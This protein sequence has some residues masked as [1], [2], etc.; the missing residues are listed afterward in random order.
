MGRISSRV[1]RRRHAM[2]RVSSYLALAA[3]G[4]LASSAYGTAYTWKGTANGNWDNT[5][6]WTFT[7]PGTFPSAAADTATFSG[8]VTANQPVLD[9]NESIGELIFSTATG[10]WNIGGTST[11]TL[12]A[13]GGIGINALSQTSG[14]TTISDNFLLAANQTWEVGAGGT[15]LFTGTIEATNPAA[16]QSL[17]IAGGGT[18]NI[19]GNSIVSGSTGLSN[20]IVSSGTLD[21]SGGGVVNTAALT[22]SGGTVIDDN[23]NG[24][25]T[26]P[27]AG[28]GYRFG[29]PGTT[30]PFVTNL[31]G[32]T[33]KL[34]GNAGTD[35]FEELGTTT[36]GAGFNTVTVSSN[37]ATP[38][39]QLDTLNRAVGGGILFVNGTGLGTTGSSYGQISIANGLGGTGPGAVGSGQAGTTDTPS[40]Q[41]AAI[42]PYVLGEVP[43]S[44]GAVGSQ[45]GV[46]DTFVAYTSGGTLRP[47]NPVD[48]YSHVVNSTVNG[49]NVYINSATTASTAT[50]NSL[51]INGGDLAIGD[52]QTVTDSS[53]ALLFVSSNGIAP[54]NTTGTF[55]LGNGTENIVSVNPGITGTISAAL[56]GSA[57][58]TYEG[59]GQLNLT[60]GSSTY[61]GTF[62]VN[63]GTLQFGPGGSTPNTAN[64]VVNAGTAAVTNGTNPNYTGTMTVNGGTLQFGNG[65]AGNDGSLSN[66]SSIINLGT[67]GNG[68]VVIDNTTNQTFAGAINFPS[69]G[70]NGNLFV[71]G[72]G[73][74]TLSQ[75]LPMNSGPGGAPF[76]WLHNGYNA[77]ASSSPITINGPITQVGPSNQGNAYF[78]VA[79]NDPITFTGQNTAE[80]TRFYMEG[81]PTINPYTSAFTTPT[82]GATK[83]V[84]GINVTLTPASGTI[85]IGSGFTGSGVNATPNS[86][87]PTFGLYVSNSNRGSGVAST[88]PPTAF[89]TSN[90]SI[91]TAG[92][93]SGNQISSG[94]VWDG[95]YNGGTAW[96]VNAPLAASAYLVIDADQNLNGTTPTYA[97]MYVAPNVP[98]G[99]GYFATN[100]QLGFA[101]IGMGYAGGT[102]NR[103]VGNS[104]YLSLGSGASFSNLATGATTYIGYDGS[105]LVDMASGSTFN[106]YLSV[107]VNGDTGYS[108]VASAINMQA[109][110]TFNI[111]HG[112]T[113]VANSFQLN[114]SGNGANGESA[115]LNIIGGT[116]NDVNSSGTTNTGAGLGL[117]GT[118]NSSTNVTV[119]KLPTAVV[120]M[121]SGGILRT[122]FISAQPITFNKVSDAPT[123]V[124]FNGGE[125]DYNGA[126][127]QANFITGGVAGVYINSNGATIGTGFAGSTVSTTNTVTITEGLMAP[128]G[129]GVTQ[130]TLKSGPAGSGYLAPPVVVIT[131]SQGFD[132]TAYATIDSTP[133]DANY[134][135]ITGFTVTNPGFNL[136]G[137]PT[138]S[139][140]GG[141]GT[142]PAATAYSIT[143]GSNSAAGGLTKTFGGTLVL[144]GTYTGA[145]GLFSLTSTGA[146]AGVGLGNIPAIGAGN[147]PAGTR[148]NTSSYAGPTVIEAGTLAL[149]NSSTNN[150]IPY[151]SMVVVGDVP[152]DNGAVFDVSGVT[153][154]GAFQLGPNQILSGFGTI[155]GTGGITIGAATGSNFG[156]GTG[157]NGLPAIAANGSGSMIAPGISPTIGTA[158][159]K[160]AG[161]STPVT[162]KLTLTTSGASPLVTT[163]G[164]NG[165]YFWKLNLDSGGVATASTPATS[166]TPATATGAGVD[167]SGTNWDAVIMDTVNVT[168][169]SG[170]P[171]NVTAS[172]F[173][174]GGT[175]GVAIGP[176]NTQAYAWVIARV[177]DSSLSN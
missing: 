116:V 112:A 83:T 41:N 169:F 67:S 49:N 75:G 137:T 125:L 68:N 138:L 10:G 174:G 111:T 160:A 87:S 94:S 52:A 23:T 88:A 100:Y 3:G 17:T 34:I 90:G 144:S 65:T 140:V 85:S 1:P 147:A 56:A 14:T 80:I 151:S 12:N 19:Q 103:H 102:P 73:G 96:Y 95:Y 142:A 29:F 105:A 157:S 118:A 124:N 28:A 146:T 37:G 44:S 166:G 107:V 139:F 35:T 9:L 7:A 115:F 21:V 155:K 72:T 66:A 84:P 165:G 40:V 120:N 113:T 177:N 47:L 99:M 176:A 25:P 6:N 54:A 129:N 61:S 26:N 86:G 48:E 70:N 20:I 51:V 82:L 134:G 154:T 74:L 58:I 92:G 8:T 2:R 121:D 117:F 43:V 130:I 152:A 63:A 46:P 135:K 81:V 108:G 55:V 110:S 24:A 69:N 159:G 27:G 57:P 31:N 22:I 78:F 97:A 168:S 79:T 98:V 114:N 89:F 39:L 173:H 170:S 106:N 104:G 53:G 171:F 32:G 59:P 11:F 161:S 136:S 145:G 101:G 143:V 15:L 172:G 163:L 132:A 33:F 13:V 133:G 119:T 149:S 38:T 91:N 126:A 77:N 162:G 158:Q 156:G 36:V 128:S 153:T 64:V 30:P 62:T 76:V 60:S 4:A 93:G 122:N 150:N 5:S 42:V 123:Y 109:G 141:G 16:A 50:I 45:T 167:V 164:A 148:N 131:D 127:N 18:I 71:F 175:T